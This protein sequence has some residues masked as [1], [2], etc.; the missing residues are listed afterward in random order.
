M[1][2]ATPGQRATRKTLVGFVSSR[3]GDKSVKVTIPYK[4]PHPRYHK[5]ISRKTEVHVHDE[6]NEAN[7]GDKVE[8]TPCRPLSKT[9]H[10]ELVQIVEKSHGTVSLKEGVTE[11]PP[12][13]KV[14]ADEIARANAEAE[15]EGEE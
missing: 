2:T 7:V 3:M 9:K 4:T 6:K 5:V 12:E 11:L 15:K 1:S 14:G 8:I 10:Y 13:E